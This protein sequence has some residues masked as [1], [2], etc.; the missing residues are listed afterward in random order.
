MNRHV[1]SGQKL[2]KSFQRWVVICSPSLPSGFASE[3]GVF[4]FEQRRINRGTRPMHKD[5]RN[6]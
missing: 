5:Q 3:E 2:N 4:Y 6:G 1:E